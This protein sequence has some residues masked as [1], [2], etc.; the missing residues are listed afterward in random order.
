MSFTGRALTHYVWAIDGTAIGGTKEKS[1]SAY[2]DDIRYGIFEGGV[3]KTLHT[4]NNERFSGSFDELPLK[5]DWGKI[6]LENFEEKV[7]YQERDE[8]LTRP[9]QKPFARS[10]ATVVEADA[11]VRKI[12]REE[13]EA[14]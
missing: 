14:E 11:E 8:A 3:E 7:W 10:G 4:E 5:F 1:S 2:F 12:K 6:V 13:W 9:I